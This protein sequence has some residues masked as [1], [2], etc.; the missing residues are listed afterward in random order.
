[1][2]ELVVREPVLRELVVRELEARELELRERS[3]F[4][5]ADPVRDTGVRD[6]DD[7]RGV[8]AVRFAADERVVL[9]GVGLRGVMAGLQ[10]LTSLLHS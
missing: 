4:D 8:G 6:D 7:R 3:V 10:S 1:M 5:R 2:R 9:L